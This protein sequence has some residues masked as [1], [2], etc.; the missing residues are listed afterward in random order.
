[1]L[2]LRVYLLRRRSG[3]TVTTM[4]GLC[5]QYPVRGKRWVRRGVEH[6]EMV[7]GVS[8]VQSRRSM[9]AAWLLLHYFSSKGEILEGI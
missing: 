4:W 7:R 3:R 6:K 8:W 2:L 9:L 5:M 1:M